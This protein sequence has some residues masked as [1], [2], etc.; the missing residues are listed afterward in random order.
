LVHDV[1]VA[2]ALVLVI[3]GIWP[4]L[5]PNGFRAA[6][7]QAAETA[8]RTLRVVGLVSMASGVGLLYLV[9]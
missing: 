6:L 5:S 1:L 4:F 7:L 9:N 3:E 8:P 2:L